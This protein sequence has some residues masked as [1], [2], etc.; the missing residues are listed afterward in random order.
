[1][2]GVSASSP[3]VGIP[4]SFRSH[5]IGE[6]EPPRK[7]ALTGNRTETIEIGLSDHR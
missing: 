1:L 5:A 4:C 3:G 6:A 2:A 7:A